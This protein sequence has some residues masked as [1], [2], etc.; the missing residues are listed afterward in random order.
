MNIVAFAARNVKRNWHR[1]LVTTLAMALAGFIMIL[2][3][4]L[5][6]GLMQTSE[7]NAVA[8]NLGDIQ[9]HVEGYRDDPDLYMRMDD[10]DALVSKIQQAGLYATQ[11]LYGFGLA[12][13]GTSSAGVQL[14]G[15]NP[16]NEKTVTLIHQHVMAG[17]WLDPLEPAGVVIGRK[18]ARTLGVGLGDEIIFLGQASDGSMANDL[19]HV[20]G[21]MKSVAQDIDRGAI[22]MSEDAFRD[23]MM[24]PRG[25]HEIAVMRPDRRADLEQARSHVAT[26]AGEYETVSWDTLM[27]VIAR[28][29]EIMDAQ[30][31]IMI[32]ITYVAV[33][34]VVLNAILMSVFERIHEFGVMKAIGVSPWQIVLLI[35]SETLIQVLVA[36]VLALISGWPLALYYQTHGI[37]L[38]AIAG[39]TTFGGIAID[40]IWYAYVTPNSLI[41]P[42]AF[43]YLIAVLA[44]IYPAAK[45][46]VIQPVQAIYYR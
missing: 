12:A 18:L 23:L 25:A 26:L 42:V 10:A 15:I 2:F 35:F 1:S 43:L 40:P 39:S 36:S 38:S 7:R 5:S 24:L 29:L 19:Y 32:L 45:A 41:L 20:R 16:E 44:V 11:R 37:D 28:I 3:A 9:I 46:A 14:R 34:M 8:M 17:Q 6:E 13:A 22:F 31:I 30:I 4:S 33:A 21:I 27:P